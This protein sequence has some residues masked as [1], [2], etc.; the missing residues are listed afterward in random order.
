M[1]EQD[2]RLDTGFQFDDGV[3]DGL[4]GSTVDLHHQITDVTLRSEHLS[5]HIEVRKDQVYIPKHTRPVAMNAED[6]VGLW[7][8]VGQADLREVDGADRSTGV[9]VVDDLVRYI[10][11]DCR[12]RLFGGAT[13]VR[14]EKRV[15]AA[16]QIAFPVVGDAAGLH[17]MRIHVH[18]RSRQVTALQRFDEVGDDDHA[19]SGSFPLCASTLKPSCLRMLT[20]SSDTPSSRRILILLLGYDTVCRGGEKHISGPAAVAS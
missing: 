7:A 19:T 2:T 15:G 3:L 6:S 4:R 9:D 8:A 1:G 14:R 5:G 20:A 18:V 17:V 11:A 10:Y 12:L 16:A 13:N